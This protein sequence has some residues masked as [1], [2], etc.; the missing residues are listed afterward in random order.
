MILNLS[1]F[2]LPPKIDA[3]L[4]SFLNFIRPWFHKVRG[5]IWGAQP[6]QSTYQISTWLFVRGL[7]LVYAIAFLSLSV[8]LLGLIG[9]QGISP[10]KEYFAFL[11]ESQGAVIFLKLPSLFWILSA[12]WFL[13]TVCVLGAAVSLAAFLGFFQVWAMGFCWLAYLSFS[14]ATSDFLAFQWDQLLLEAGF[15]A[16]FLSAWAPKPTGFA[17]NDIRI[18][19]TIRRLY[20]WLIFRIFYFSGMMKIWTEDP[21]WK[22]LSALRHHLETQPLP[23]PAAWLLVNGPS[24]ILKGAS[25]LVPSFEI[26][27]VFFLIGPRRIRMF[28]VGMLCVHQGFIM[29]TGSFGFLNLL[30]LLLG[31]LVLDDQ[32]FVFKKIQSMIS[33][34]KPS[35]VQ[36][37]WA[38]GIRV[39][40]LVLALIGTGEQIPRALGWNA[41]ADALKS[42][43]DFL[44]PIRSFNF[45]SLFSN[46][47]GERLSLSIEGSNNRITWFPYP[48]KFK[49]DVAS[50]KPLTWVAPFQ[51]RLDWQLWIAA[52]GRYSDNPWLLRLCDR[53][54][55]QSP[56]VLSF[57]ESNPF[58]EGAPRYVQVAIYSEHMTTWAEKKSGQGFW[59]RKR[60]GVYLPPA[61]LESY[62]S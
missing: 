59:I 13:M 36:F 15:L 18:S 42:G 60:L 16:I 21:A 3:A 52:M 10:V 57:F 9:S 2:K 53:I 35:G 48:L 56:S 38:K 6:I 46:V 11:K 54:L 43:R 24:W 28:A 23:S 8:Q 62:S 37:T 7:A 47:P 55:K 26:L 50:Q 34:S 1:K 41:V 40:V 5:V 22:N 29:L 33:I 20:L 12:D 27:L 4:Q 39:A 19:S 58:S 14:N 51:P 44:K 45:Y 49:P 31:L 61:S 17:E 30:V 25:A 32:C